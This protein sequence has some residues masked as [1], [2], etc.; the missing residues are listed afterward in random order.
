MR[1]WV[2]LA[3]LIVFWGVNW[4]ME[5]MRTHWAFF[6]LW[7]GYCLVV[8]AVVFQRTG[9]SLWVRGRARY[10]KLFIV[11]APAWWLF[12]VLNWRTGNWFY[13]GRDQVSDVT[14]VLLGSL[15]FSTVIP[16]VFGSAELVRSFRVARFGRAF[17]MDRLGLLFGL[18][19]LAMFALLLASPRYFF[20]FL[21][22]SLFLVIDSIND[23]CGYRSL[24]REASS[25]DW[26]GGVSLAAGALVCG[27]FWELWNYYSYPRWVYDVPFVD[28]WK[29]F[30]MPLLGYGGYL[31][32]GLELFALYHLAVGITGGR[33]TDT[34]VRLGD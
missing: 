24:L 2:G 31:P 13:Q 5:G 34:Y 6:P 26:R 19:G 4:E 10:V 9:T 28:F 25:G 33:S 23:R 30:E 14:Y 32:F 8:D 11:S 17:E 29:V 20:P 1:G 18:S 7:L 27:F 3:L 21:W 22:I 12:E 15:S 16:A